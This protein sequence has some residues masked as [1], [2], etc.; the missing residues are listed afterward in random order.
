VSSAPED[1]LV[2]WEE[3]QDIELVVLRR[4]KEFAMGSHK[5]VF[6]GAGFDLVGLREWEP[7]DRVAGIDWP[8]SS[9]NNFSPLLTREFEQESTASVVIV[10]DSSLSTRC[11]A[12]GTPIAKVI[13]RTV[14]TL[15]LAAAFFQDL[16]G[17]ITMDG[18]Q[19]RLVVP[20]RTGRNH[21]V[22]CAEV[23][24]DC[25]SDDRT[26]KTLHQ[27]A[28]LAGLLRKRSLIPVVTDF[29]ADDPKSVI[30]ECAA[31]SG[32]HD[33]FMVVIDCA[34]A[35]KLPRVSAGWIEA[36]DVESGVSRVFS[37]GEVELF[38]RRVKSWQDES[39]QLG[40]ACGLEIVRVKPG[41]E[42]QALAAFLNGRRAQKQ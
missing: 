37:S 9:L 5:S 26:S 30:E 39:V 27:V 12:G 17:L 31:L 35:F 28:S 14:A 18:T 22:H 15:S 21:A 10:A 2:S 13:A 41:N 25:L 7:G 3:I 19:R 42:H 11:G 36:Y 16:V 24:Q 33:V 8:Q 32:V 1:R 23:Y 38:E 29:L 4:M 40:Q 20:L 6:Q 34:F